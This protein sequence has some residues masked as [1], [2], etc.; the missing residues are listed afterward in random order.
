MLDHAAASVAQR[1]DL[2]GR[3]GALQA[4][5]RARHPGA[6]PALDGIAAELRTALHGGPA[7][8]PAARR[9]LAAYEAGLARPQVSVR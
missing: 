3:F 7:D 5:H 6:D 4:K 9:L 1:D 2:R 8:L